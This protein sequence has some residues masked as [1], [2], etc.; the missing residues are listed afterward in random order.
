VTAEPSVAFTAPSHDSAP[1]E[2]RVNFGVFAGREATPA[3]LD[4]LARVLV[5]QVGDVS[6]VAEQRHE[7]GHGTE[8]V[9]HQI[10]IELE[11]STLPRADGDREALGARLV[12]AAERWAVA[13]ATDRQTPDA[14]VEQ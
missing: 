9:L 8:A 13:C 1:F 5:P 14:T 10:R 4:E 6:I 12:E 7:V 2:V 3:E 11:P